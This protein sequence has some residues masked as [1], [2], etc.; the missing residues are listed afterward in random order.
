[1][2]ARAGGKHDPLA[3]LLARIEELD[4]ALDEALT[5]RDF[6]RVRRKPSAPCPADSP[7]A[8]KRAGGLILAALHATLLEAPDNLG[9][10]TYYQLKSCCKLDDHVFGLALNELMPSHL[11][12]R[13]ISDQRYYFLCRERR[14]AALLKTRKLKR[15]A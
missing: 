3:G 14:R 8:I 7:Q 10:L 6:K 15:V 1:M 2:S 4:R 12:T 5:G 9:A 13:T 11:R